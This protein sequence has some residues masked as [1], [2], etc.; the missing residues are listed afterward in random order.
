MIPV[1]ADGIKAA[2]LIGSGIKK[3]PSIIKGKHAYKK[4]D[5]SVD[6]VVRLKDVQHLM[7]NGDGIWYAGG[8]FHSY[9]I[10]IGTNSSVSHGGLITLEEGGDVPYLA[11]MLEG[12]GMRHRPLIESVQKYPGKYFWSPINHN[13]FPNFDGDKVRKEVLKS[14][15]TGYG[16]LAVFVMALSVAP[17]SRE[18]VYFFQKRFDRWLSGCPSFCSM[19]QCEW[20]IRA[21]QQDPVPGRDSR[22]TSPQ[23]TFQSLLWTPEKYAL[24]P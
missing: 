14:I 7:Q 1:T 9:L 11:E 23:D 8:A 17:L 6:L 13:A 20:P 10:R 22:L 3:R 21:K 4:S 12:Y 24:M 16:R 15:G 19:A 5:E 2:C 18:L